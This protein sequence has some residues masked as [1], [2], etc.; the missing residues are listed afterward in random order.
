MRVRDASEEWKEERTT[1]RDDEEG[2]RNQEENH[3][4]TN[5]NKGDWE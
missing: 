3:E 1:Q 2:E 4:R 5:L